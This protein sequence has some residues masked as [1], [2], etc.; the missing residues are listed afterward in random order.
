MTQKNPGFTTLATKPEV[1]SS[2]GST[3]PSDTISDNLAL[4]PL[5][6]NARRPHIIIEKRILT[7]IRIVH[8]GFARPIQI[9]NSKFEILVNSVIQPKPSHLL[10]TAGH[11]HTYQALEH[12]AASRS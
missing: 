2:L 7:G 6:L 11:H 8:P 9:Y 5:Q 3:R 10:Y 12:A 1:S 4:L